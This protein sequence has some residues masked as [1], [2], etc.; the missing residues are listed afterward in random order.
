[1]TRLS[2]FREVLLYMKH[3]KK[4]WIAPLIILVVALAVFITLAEGSALAPLIYA[5]F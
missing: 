1:M 4:W 3:H 2:L 5:L